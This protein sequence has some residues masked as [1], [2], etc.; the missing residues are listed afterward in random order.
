MSVTIKVKKEIAKLID[1]LVELNIAKS[2]NEAV[3]LLIE[4]GRTEIERRIKEEEEVR[5][6]VNKWLKECFPYEIRYF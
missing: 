1:R 3:N 4:Y 2:K 6:L 5:N